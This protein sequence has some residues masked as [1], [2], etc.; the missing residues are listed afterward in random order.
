MLLKKNVVADISNTLEHQ[1]YLV[2]SV[3]PGFDY[4]TGIFSK[5][6]IIAIRQGNDAVDVRL[7]KVSSSVEDSKEY[8]D[9]EKNFKMVS[10]EAY[11]MGEKGRGLHLYKLID[12]KWRKV[13][14]P[15]YS[16]Y[17]RNVDARQEIVWGDKGTLFITDESMLF[18]SGILKKPGK[19]KRV[20]YLI[21]EGVL[22]I[23]LWEVEE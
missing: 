20:D 5:F 13:L 23:H 1:G 22:D 10:I 15:E 19:Y 17:L 21:R 3:L 18:V 8:K 12:G 6:D 16:H 4:D 2:E 11:K 9:I 7:I 14:N